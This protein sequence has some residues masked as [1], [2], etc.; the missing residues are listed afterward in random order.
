MF[1]EQTFAQLRMGLTASDCVENYAT[2]TKTQTT[3]VNA[4]RSFA[5]NRCGTKTGASFSFLP[6]IYFPP[7]FCFLSPWKV[8]FTAA[9]ICVVADNSHA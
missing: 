1:G 2:K 9:E 7:G 6:P 5:G 3:H 4:T 8:S